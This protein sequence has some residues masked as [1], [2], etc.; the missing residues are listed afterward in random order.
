MPRGTSRDL[1]PR[2]VNSLADRV[3]K[4]TTESTRANRSGK[5]QIGG[6]SNAPP[7]VRQET[8]TKA[9]L[10]RPHLPDRRVDTKARRVSSVCRDRNFCCVIDRTK[11]EL[12][13]GIESFSECR[14][15]MCRLQRSLPGRVRPPQA[16]QQPTPN[17]RVLYPVGGFSL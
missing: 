3:P 9:I 16:E 2:P 10:A 14:C 4:P 8:K 17:H 1:I 13:Q 12:V 5:L 7:H 11:L 15:R 6:R